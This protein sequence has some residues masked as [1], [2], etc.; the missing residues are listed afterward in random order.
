MMR[1]AAILTPLVLA[2]SVG[3]AQDV[4]RLSPQSVTRPGALYNPQVSGVVWSPVGAT[5]TY[6]KPDGGVVG[7]DSSL[8]A[9]DAATGKETLLYDP[10]AQSVKLDPTTAQW[11]PKGDAVLLSDGND[12]WLI[13]VAT[14]ALRQVTHSALPEQEVTFS[15]N[16][17][18]LA[19][20]RSNDLYAVDLRTGREQRLT[21]DGSANVLNGTLDWVYNEELGTSVQQPAYAWSPDSTKIGFMRLDEQRVT[22]YP[23]LDYTQVP[24]QVTL[25]QYPHA[26]ST[27]PTVSL[28][29][30]A[31][32]QHL[33]P[34]PIPLRAQTEYVLPVFTWTR[35]SREFA[36]L[37]LN[38]AHTALSLSLWN[39]ITRRNRLLFTEQNERWIN[40]YI[41]VA[42]YFLADN[43][44]F[45][46]YS[47]RDGW[48]HLYLFDRNGKQ[49]QQLTKGEW[50]VDADPFSL[51]EPGQPFNVD[52]KN[53][54]IYFSASEKN[55][56]ER[57]LTR[58][59][60][61]GTQLTRLTETPGTHFATLSA[62]GQYLTEVFQSVTQ[63]PVTSLL[64]SDG[65]P[66]R[67]LGD[68]KGTLS[69]AAPTV[70]FVTLKTA[71][72]VDLYGELFKPA[73]F[74]AGKKYP[75]VVYTYAG[76]TIQLVANRSDTTSLLNPQPLDLLMLQQGY[77]VWRLDNRGT[78]GRG[79]A[80]QDGIFKNLGKLE[81]QDQ[82]T[83]VAY[84][85][86]LP[87]VDPGRLAILGRSY[88]GFMTLYALIHE[89][90]VFR[91]GTASAPVTD[92]H[93]YDTIYTE[94]YMHTPAE[95]PQGY[96]ESS[97]VN[98]GPQ[99]QDPL[100]VIFGTADDNVQTQNTVNFLNGM[101][102][103]YRPF[104]VLILPGQNH[105]FYN[106]GLTA[107]IAATMA[108]FGQNL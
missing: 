49:L 84:L 56:L 17:K 104:D 28:W 13:D 21:L 43:Q 25:Q 47:E 37:T 50:I 61:D 94:R 95:N 103:A 29:V 101:M 76:P 102:Q 74:D 89:P 53:G 42:P 9:Y 79:H 41:Y 66:V 72:G 20:V 38:R 107:S 5:M 70:D 52:E 81:L 4:D 45:I 57:H 23:I 22:R 67:V 44:R 7:G 59:R 80:F 90:G 98:L 82:L 58:V 106:D 68:S 19:F 33:R 99:I 54:W 55:V 83:G 96:Q 92:W 2:A 60:L 105:D 16:G 14:D 31:P 8:W 71:D 27:N 87:F 78:I 48:F 73:D 34:Q 35:D 15:P 97:L 77:L 10:K 108:F 88:G 51:V 63:T 69:Y 91:C 3:A 32:G 85:K 86:S 64:R 30:A 100:F 24:P 75:V 12:L 36:Y 40:E 46:W 62:D 6:L 39:P 93:L 1:L 26:G 18:Q 11:S 65:T